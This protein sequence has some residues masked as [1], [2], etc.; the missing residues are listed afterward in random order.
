MPLW[1][2]N[3]LG[4]EGGHSSRLDPGRWR[5]QPPPRVTSEAPQARYRGTSGTRE[6]LCSRTARHS[7]GALVSVGLD[8]Q[9]WTLLGGESSHCSRQSAGCNQPAPGSQQRGLRSQNPTLTKHCFC[10]GGAACDPHPLFPPGR[11]HARTPACSEGKP[12]RSSSARRGCG[13]DFRSWWTH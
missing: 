13:I 11:P 10:R 3:R 6:D 4:V 2:Q 9:F 12:S 8:S 1:R 7:P 5:S